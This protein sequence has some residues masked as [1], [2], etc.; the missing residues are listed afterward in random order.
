MFYTYV[1]YSQKLNKRYIGSTSDID[2]RINE[3]NNG[4]SKFT[5]SGIPWKLIYKET[6]LTNSET[7]VRE[8]FLKSGVGRKFLDDILKI[9]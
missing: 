5:K 9:W 7:R 8:N 6:F 1:L 3:H 2:K 4:K